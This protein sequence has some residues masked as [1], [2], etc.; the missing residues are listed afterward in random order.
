M[1]DRLVKLVKLFMYKHFSPK[2]I[3][4][5]R[6]NYFLFRL[7]SQ[8]IF[9]DEKELLIVSKI[10]E[11]DDIVVDV[12]A[13]VGV[14]TVFILQLLSERGRILSFEPIPETYDI[15]MNNA[16]RLC[17]A[18][19]MP[20]NLA[21]SDHIGS[22]DMIVPTDDGI[23]NFYLSHIRPKGATYHVGSALRI[24]TETLDNILSRFD[25]RVDFLK[26]DVEGAELLVFRG[27]ENSIAKHLPHIM[28]EISSGHARYGY[29]AEDIFNYLWDHGYMSYVY[30]NE[31]LVNCSGFMKGFPNYFFIHSTKTESIFS[32]LNPI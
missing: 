23:E 12:G 29:A 7:K 31:T 16:R 19:V 3:H 32:S 9:Q 30:K 1:K 10:I 20:F 18:R 13:N 27:G 2:V 17:G 28:C 26:C 15:L 11:P 24:E 21:L 22:I 5:L 8:E 4:L 25:L 6:K 14:Y